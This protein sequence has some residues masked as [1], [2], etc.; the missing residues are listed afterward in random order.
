MK[1]KRT[2]IALAAIVGLTATAGA[3]FAFRKGGES[4]HGSEKI[5]KYVDYRVNDVLDDLEADETQRTR[6]HATKDRLVGQAEQL[7]ASRGELRTALMDQWN[8]EKPDADAIHKLIDDRIDELRALA[9]QAA[10]AGLEVH[11][12]LNA[13]QRA[14]LAEFANEKK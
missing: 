10:D 4:C 6:I 5:K 13:Q 2:L 14:E 1:L 3:A 8:Q 7:F 9:H 12:T 11:G